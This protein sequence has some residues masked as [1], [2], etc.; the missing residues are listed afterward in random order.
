MANSEPGPR[1][2]EGQSLLY[3]CA[4]DPVYRLG[5]PVDMPDWVCL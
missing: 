5:R 1:G 2:L 3:K 4:S